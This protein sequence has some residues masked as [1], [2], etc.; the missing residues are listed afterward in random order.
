MADANLIKN[1]DLARV[2]EQEFVY[3][4]TGSLKKLFEAL[5]VTRK[6]A[7]VI[8]VSAADVVILIVVGFA[9]PIPTAWVNRQAALSVL[10][11]HNVNADAGNRNAASAKRIK[12]RIIFKGIVGLLGDI[13]CI[14]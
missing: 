12:L 4:F 5:S 14:E 10:C 8:N 11:G 7:T 1:A 2:R 6:M 13:V 9:V 3:L